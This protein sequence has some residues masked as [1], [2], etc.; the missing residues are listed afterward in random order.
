MVVMVV[1][2]VKVFWV[3]WAKDPIDPENFDNFNIAWVLSIVLNVKV[4]PLFRQH[5]SQNVAQT[6]AKP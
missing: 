6:A 2:I 1:K 3:Y 5:F 4:S